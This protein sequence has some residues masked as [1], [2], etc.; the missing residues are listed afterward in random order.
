ML[1]PEDDRDHRGLRFKRCRVRVLVLVLERPVHRQH[2]TD[3]KQN[4][5]TRVHAA[6]ADRDAGQQVRIR[7]QFVAW[8]STTPTAA[9]NR[10][11]SSSGIRSRSIECVRV[12]EKVGMIRLGSN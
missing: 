5:P 11:R 6:R 3:G 1:M 10:N 2:D 12:G 7:R 9:M 8:N 4:Q